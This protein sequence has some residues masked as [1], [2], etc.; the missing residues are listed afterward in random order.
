MWRVELVEWVGCRPLAV[1][2][3]STTQ[4]H[5]TLVLHKPLMLPE[6]EASWVC[7]KAALQSC[8]L[9]LD[10]SYHPEQQPSALPHSH[11]TIHR[12]RQYARL[13]LP[14]SWYNSRNGKTINEINKSFIT[15]VVLCSFAYYTKLHAIF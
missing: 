13:I 4:G 14:M 7:V 9:T 2:N 10:R 1:L 3:A 5:F 8:A 15:S 6:T 12:N 11:Y